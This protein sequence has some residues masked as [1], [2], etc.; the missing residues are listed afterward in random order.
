MSTKPVNDFLFAKP[1]MWEKC[2]DIILFIFNNLFCAFDAHGI[3]I[4]TFNSIP[5]GNEWIDQYILY[6]SQD[7]CLVFDAPHRDDD[8]TN[9]RSRYF[10][11]R[12]SGSNLGETDCG[13]DCTTCGSGSDTLLEYE[14]PIQNQIK[15]IYCILYISHD[16]CLVLMCDSIPNI[17][18]GYYY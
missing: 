9:H 17:R 7:P 10:R 16:L 3:R 15:T 5:I 12:I 18:D 8:S 1:F 11:V 13:S 6:N 14:L 4:C 2:E